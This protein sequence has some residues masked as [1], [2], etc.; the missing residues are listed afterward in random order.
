MLLAF[1]HVRCTPA[2]RT[3]RQANKI[4]LTATHLLLNGSPPLRPSLASVD[5]ELQQLPAAVE[6]QAAQAAQAP[7]SRPASEATPGYLVVDNVDEGGKSTG[8]GKGEGVYDTHVHATVRRRSDDGAGGSGGGGGGGP[9]PL[10]FEEDEDEDDGNNSGGDRNGGGAEAE[11][12]YDAMPATLA[13]KDS[14]TRVANVLYDAGSGGPCLSTGS[15]AAQA[16]GGDG[17]AAYDDMHD[18]LLLNP[19]AK[20]GKTPAAAAAAAAVLPSVAGSGG[21]GGGIVLGN[22]AIYAEDGEEDDEADDE[23][24]GGGGGGGC[25]PARVGRGSP[26][27]PVRAPTVLV[28]THARTDLSTQASGF[29]AAR[30]VCARARALSLSHTHTLYQRA[31]YLAKKKGLH[32]STC[33]RCPSKINVA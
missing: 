22:E 29:D 7:R 14:V 8:G 33:A 26:R 19:G 17:E 28:R 15:G 20:A 25:V 31:G 13:K 23:F 30:C 10:V 4:E 16:Q 18:S 6:A 9:P 32:R 12:D 24:F 1:P 11:H 27:V 5:G 21:S 3:R 2:G